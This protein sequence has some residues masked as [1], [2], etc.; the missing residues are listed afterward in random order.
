MAEANWVVHKTDQPGEYTFW[1]PA[2]QCGHC[3]WT[4]EA[5]RGPSWNWN[6]D[7]VKPTLLPAHQPMTS[8][9]ITYRH[10]TGYT[11]DNPAPLG[12]NGP[13]TTDVCHFHMVDGNLHYC[14]DCTHALANKVVP[15]EPF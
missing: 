12:Y 5:G 1:C 7:Y 6:G 4:P 3:F 2:C 10:P 8:M 11:N 14:A 9:K 15:M 13:Y